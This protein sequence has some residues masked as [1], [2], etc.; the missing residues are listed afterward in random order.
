MLIVSGTSRRENQRRLR[1]GFKRAVVPVG[2]SIDRSRPGLEWKSWYAYWKP[3]QRFFEAD[4]RL[5][6]RVN[7]LKKTWLALLRKPTCQR[8]QRDY[9]WRYFCLLHHTLR[10][11]REEPE[12][13]DPISVLRRILGFET[14][15]IQVR[16]WE[17]VAAG[18]IDSRNPVFLLG[19][20]PADAPLPSS[21]HAPLVMPT[22]APSPFYCYRQLRLAVEPEIAAIVCPSAELKDRIASFGPIDRLARLLSPQGDPRWRPRA[23]LLARRVLVPLLRS[24]MREKRLAPRSAPLS[25]LDLGAGTGHLTAVAWR[26]VFRSLTASRRL[27]AAL[28]FVDAA[29][30]CFGRSFGLARET[31]NVSHVEW[32]KAEYRKFLD[33]DDWLRSNGP[34]DWVFMCRLLGNTSNVIIEEV[35]TSAEEERVDSRGCNPCECLAPSRQPEGLKRLCVRTV[36]R[37][38]GSGTFM[39][40]FSLADYF[41]AMRA[42]MADSLDA[43]IPGASY[44]P[45]RRFNPAAL[46]TVA[47]RSVIAQLMKVASAIVIEDTDLQPEH[48]VGHR[49]EF[50]LDGTAAV[51]CVRDGFTTEAHHYVITNSA[52]AD[53][54][55]GK[56]LW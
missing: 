13:G 37:S 42:V 16:G 33:D 3:C 6:H 22:G 34:F 19:R 7:Q 10:I 32:T 49:Q 40:Q 2:L 54:L 30:P 17:G 52:R 46:T 48:L 41:A 45:V 55:A 38:I 18:L 4:R 28:H 8:R 51:H 43:V 1:A 36:R 35:D 27:S 11:A 47:G 9:C 5:V 31:E 53:R 50:G 39:P 24:R 14:F 29:G 20:L 21:R 44:L 15:T 56:R 26:E 23:R 25:L 12:R